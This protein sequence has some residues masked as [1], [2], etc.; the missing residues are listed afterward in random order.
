MEIQI[1]DYLN[2]FWTGG[3]IC[4]LAQILIDKTKLTPARILVLFVTS[5]VFL[6]AIG[7]YEPFVKFA[8][9][10]ATVPLTGFGFVMAQGI[11]E[12]IK[13]HGFFG[14][15]TGGLMSSSAGISAA[16]FFGYLFSVF[17]KSGD[18]S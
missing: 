17:F 14:I 10:G 3:L 12:Q 8:K 6:T 11:K 13:S 5:G 16:I 15:L 18:K 9:A 2:S 4:L 1:M 7:I